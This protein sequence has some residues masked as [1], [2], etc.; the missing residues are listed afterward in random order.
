M[1]PIPWRSSLEG[2]FH[3]DLS[4]DSPFGTIDAAR[5][6]YINILMYCWG[7][8]WF[9]CKRPSIARTRAVQIH[10]SRIVEMGPTFGRDSATPGVELHQTGTDA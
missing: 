1:H 6:T 7:K 9:D 8:R 5:A 10:S 2:D 4:H 3:L